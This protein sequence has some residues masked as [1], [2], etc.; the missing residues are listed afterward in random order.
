MGLTDVFDFSL[1]RANQFYTWGWR[2]SVVGAVVTMLGI[3][4]LWLGTRVRDHDVESKISETTLAAE[5]LHKDNLTLQTNLEKE[6]IARLQLEGKTEGFGLDIAKANERAEQAK[7]RSAE[8]NEKAAAIN[9]RALNLE[10]SNLALRS[11]VATLETRAES[12]GKQV[13]I[14]QTETADAKRRQAEAEIKLAQVK[15]R[16]EPRGTPVELIAGILRTAP[17][18]KVIIVRQKGDRDAALFAGP[19]Q[20]AL[21]MGGWEILESKVVPDITDRGAG[22]G[23]MMFWMRSLDIKSASM[24]ALIRALTEAGFTWSGMSDQALPDDTLRLIIY[25]KP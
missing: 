21:I 4:A 25:P 10:S 1:E 14:L 15:K 3:A 16:L 2:L 18:A 9:E 11:Q 20:E 12:E 8:A 24:R 6:R 13:A 23:D 19:V 7:A 5:H 17:P 22:Q